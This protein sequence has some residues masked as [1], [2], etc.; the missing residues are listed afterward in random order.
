MHR[1]ELASQD[2]SAASST[3]AADVIHYGKW[4]VSCD[5][6]SGKPCYCDALTGKVA[7]VLASICVLSVLIGMVWALPM[8][9]REKVSESVAPGIDFVSRCQV[10]A[11]HLRVCLLSFLL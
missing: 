2:A 1:Q 9:S 8:A 5:V 10:F 11:P 7:L 4:R 3:D 6:V